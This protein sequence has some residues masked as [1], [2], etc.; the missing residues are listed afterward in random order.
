[1]IHFDFVSAECTPY[2]VLILCAR[3][4]TQS[5]SL[6]L[7]PQAGPEAIPTTHQQQSADL[8]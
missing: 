2:P 7:Q 3:T 6:A 5:R 8:D 4:R 1:M